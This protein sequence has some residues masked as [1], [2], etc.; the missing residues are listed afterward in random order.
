M[1]GVTRG[2]AWS[3]GAHVLDGDLVHFPVHALAARSK[4][5]D[6]SEQRLLSIQRLPRHAQHKRARLTASAGADTIHRGNA[7]I[8]TIIRSGY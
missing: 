5:E 6:K 8:L 3:H 2:D 7:A 4:D 1:M